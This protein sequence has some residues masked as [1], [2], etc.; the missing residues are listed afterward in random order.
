MTTIKDNYTNSSGAIF[1]VPF[2]SKVFAMTY[3]KKLFLEAGIP[4]PTNEWSVNDMI[5]A[6]RKI[7]KGEGIDKVYGLR[8]GVRP[9]E[10][11][12]NLYGTCRI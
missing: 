12:R 1:A 8:W 7:T 5:S 6:A 10:F 11:Y 3:N 9:M 4:Y 2:I